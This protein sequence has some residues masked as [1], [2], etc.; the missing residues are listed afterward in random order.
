MPKLPSKEYWIKRAEQTLI[1]NE[2]TALEY[3]NGL[4]TAY[5]ATIARV[6]TEI[7]AFYGRYA[8]DQKIDLAEAR[9]RLTPT[10]LKSFQKTAK[11]YLDEV[12]RLGA[13]AFTKPYR[14]YL[15]ELSGK[16]YVSRIEEL[17]ANIR[18]N[19]ETL[20]TGYNEG[21]GNTLTE[22]YKD[23]YFRTMFD[24]Q[25][26]TGFGI[27]F[28][29]PGGKSLE[30][31]VK[32]RWNGQNYSDRIWAGKKTLLI[33]TLEQT[34][35]QEFVR[36]RGSR[37]LAG[38]MVHKLGVSF[39]NAQRLIRT[40]I[41]YISNKGTIKAYAD[42]EVVHEYEYVSTLDGRTSDIC[43]EMD[44]RVFKLSEAKVGVTI[45]PLHPH[46]RSTT[47]PHFPDDEI[48]ASTEDRVARNADGKTYKL[49]K[50]ITY[51]EWA[52]EHA[53]EA[54]AK[55]VAKST[56]PYKEM[57][58]EPTA[59]EAPY[60]IKTLAKFKEHEENWYN[61]K[62]LKEISP[63]A[64]EE[65]NENLKELVDKSDFA[66]RIPDD[67]VLNQILDDGKFKTQFET[68]TSNGS[69]NK[70]A[71]KNATGQ[72]FGL[73]SDEVNAL[74][75]KDFEKYGYLASKDRFSDFSD[76]NE[77]SQYGDICIRFKRE[78]VLNRTTMTIGDSLGP[79][80]NGIIV[81]T[82]ISN[83]RVS[84]MKITRLDTLWSPGGTNRLKA[85]MNQSI[86]AH[87]VAD[88]LYESYFELQ[89][90][91]DLTISD[92]D[93]ITYNSNDY[94]GRLSEDTKKRLDK[95][96]IKVYNIGDED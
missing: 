33:D 81:S 15:K 95:L 50:D 49:G 20:S 72:L 80:R 32:E 58:K 30:T 17:V 55:K 35:S 4:K 42:S 86:D 11:R 41:N 3:E 5:E 70:D 24:V 45:P 63:R 23:A 74:E 57:D 84:G 48:S 7:D 37:V 44:G 8:K 64:A 46:C 93:S 9:R 10:E 12:E 96:G 82:S 79:A 25:K 47:I 52:K 92:I 76:S 91:G 36:G 60:T 2:M 39:S 53:D 90:H 73:S 1:Q 65:L 59:N 6:T 69:L 28:T 26:Q 18:H 67:K 77:A 89:Y 85:A 34:L 75:P 71:R 13:D 19:I 62:T 21:L 61:E 87:D 16:A 22:A 68:N 78:A 51:K 54:Y 56:K 38:E 31:A 66:M 83:P 88:T 40:E 94:S 43:I 14:D 29:S 27:S